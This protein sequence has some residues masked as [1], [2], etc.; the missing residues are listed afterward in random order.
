MTIPENSA[1]LNETRLPGDIVDDQIWT[2][3]H[4]QHLYG[5]NIKDAYQVKNGFFWPLAA[6]PEEVNYLDIA[7]GLSQECRFGGQSPFFYSVAWHTVALSYVVPD[8]LKQWA[9]M[10][11]SAEAYLSDVPR[12]IKEMPPFE[13]IKT[14]EAKL[15]AVIAEKFGM[16][17]VEPPELKPHDYLMSHTEMLVM[18]GKLGEAKLRAVGFDSEHLEKARENTYLIRHLTPEQAEKAWLDRFYE[19]FPEWDA[20]PQL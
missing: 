8:E 4:W 14:E 12:V 16:H 2:G 15:L 5:R 10:H 6:R 18:Y 9:L 7:R 20:R 13:Y 1:M 17:P 3:T 19:L 11:D